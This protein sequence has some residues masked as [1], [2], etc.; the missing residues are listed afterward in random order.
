MGGAISEEATTG[1]PW[2]KWYTWKCAC[3][4]PIRS[5]RYFFH[6]LLQCCF[7]FDDKVSFELTQDSRPNTGLS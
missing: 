6:Y 2:P 7:C 4:R 5:I 3:L 1:G